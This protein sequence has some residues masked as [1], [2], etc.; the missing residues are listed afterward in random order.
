[1]QQSCRGFVGTLVA[2]WGLSPG[3][4]EQRGVTMI[5]YQGVVACGVR[6]VVVVQHVPSHMR[7]SVDGMPLSCSRGLGCRSRHTL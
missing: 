6:A 1:V 7:R 5:T 2:S 4:A 3:R